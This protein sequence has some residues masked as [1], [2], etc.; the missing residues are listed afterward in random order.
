MTLPGRRLL[1][2][3]DELMMQRLLAN[4]LEAL[5]FDV[6]CADSVVEAKKQV[7]RCD[8]DIALIDIGLKGGLSGLH[9]GHYLAIQHPDIA[10]IYLSAVDL[11]TGTVGEGMGLPVGAGFVSKHSIGETKLLVEVINQVVRGKHV[12]GDASV[13]AP[14]A[15]ESL[16]KKG[17]RVMELVA[18]GF[19]NQYI[20]EQLGVT[21]KTVEYYVDQ[22]Y[23]ALGVGQSVNRNSRVEA[24]LRYQQ[25]S[26]S[27]DE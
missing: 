25:L 8:P 4:E 21:Q 1:V 15:L 23:R 5:G 12:V 19:S 18:S 9:F 24:A 13:A 26:G 3:E 17:R 22:G 27:G 7:K 10:Q 14:G 11:S 6:T 20:A 16:G 2:V